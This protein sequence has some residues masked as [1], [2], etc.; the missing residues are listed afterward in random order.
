MLR[1]YTI[2]YKVFDPFLISQ[3]TIMK[4]IIKLVSNAKHS[5][6]FHKFLLSITVEGEFF[7]LSDKICQRWSEGNPK[8]KKF[9]CQLIPKKKNLKDCRLKMQLQQTN[10]KSKS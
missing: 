6:L 9:N 2:E 8:I 10:G 4:Q 5:N 3:N 1:R 7:F